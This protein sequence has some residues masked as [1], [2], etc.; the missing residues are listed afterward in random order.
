MLL[1]NFFHDI[2]GAYDAG[3]KTAGLSKN[4]PQ[5]H[6]LSAGKQRF[7]PPGSSPSCPVMAFMNRIDHYL[8][9]GTVQA[10]E[11]IEPN[12]CPRNVSGFLPTPQ[13]ERAQFDGRKSC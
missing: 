7:A 4:D 1:E 13:I 9:S 6:V 10:Q 5:R 12:K 3:A 11:A 8:G 2:D